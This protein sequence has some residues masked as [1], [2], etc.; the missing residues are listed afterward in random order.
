VKAW[1]PPSVSL[2]YPVV[3]RVEQWFSGKGVTL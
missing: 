3:N 1:H 2:L